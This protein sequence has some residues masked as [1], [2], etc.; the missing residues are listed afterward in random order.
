MF[1]IAGATLM[2]EICSCH[3]F[4]SSMS[5]PAACGSRS[6]QARSVERPLSAVQCCA[7]C[8]SPPTHNHLHRLHIRSSPLPAER[9]VAPLVL[10]WGCPPWPRLPACFRSADPFQVGSALIAVS[11]PATLPTGAVV[12]LQDAHRT[13][14]KLPPQPQVLVQP[15][16][17]CCQSYPRTG[18]AAGCHPPLRRPGHRRASVVQLLR[19][20]LKFLLP[21]LQVHPTSFAFPA[22]S[23]P[24]R[25]ALPALAFLSRPGLALLWAIVTNNPNNPNNPLLL[26]SSSPLLLVSSPSP[27]LLFSSPPPLLL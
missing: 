2:P 14:W 25:C 1:G 16:L 12:R 19:A 5:I 17:A 6:R 26:F 20:L 11:P 27:L 23:A 22:P 8:T 3:F 10:R 7:G 15:L 18:R 9:G 24:T 4:K 21:P 13:F